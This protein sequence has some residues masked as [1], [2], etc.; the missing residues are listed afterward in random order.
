MR[1]RAIRSDR[2]SFRTVTFD[3]GL[4]IILA[5]KTARSSAKDTRNG[6]GK[7]LLIDI[8]HF[9]LGAEFNKSRLAVPQLHDWTFRLELEFDGHVVTA[10]RSTGHPKAVVVTGDN[11]GLGLPIKVMGRERT[12]ELDT[13][14]WCDHLGRLTFGLAPPD[15][16]SPPKLSFRSLV[17][18]FMRRDKQA[19]LSPFSFH[20]RMG[21]DEQRVC[22]A[23][24]L[25]LN[26]RYAQQWH[27]LKERRRVL[28]VLR[29]AA[30]SGLVEP[31]FGSRGKLEA[32]R[33][34]VASDV[35]KSAD[36]LA[37]FRVHPQYEYLE[38]KA[39]GLTREIHDLANANLRDRRLLEMYQ[40]STQDEDVDD[41]RVEEV[42]REAQMVFPKHVSRRLR[43][44]R[45]FHRDV[46][47]D[48]R[49]FLAVEAGRLERVVVDRERLMG[50]KT[51]DRAELLETLNTHGALSE[52]TKLRE[53]HDKLVV[54]LRDLERRLSNLKEFESGRSNLKIEQETLLQQTLHDLEQRTSTR[55]KA[56]A[57]FNSNSQ[58]L[59]DAPGNLIIEVDE[60]GY[61]FGVD[62]K[63]SGS[64]GIESMKVF[65]YDL[66]LAQLWSEREPKPGVLV[67]DS[68]IFDGVDERQ[69]A[70][71][72]RR[73]AA[74][75]DA[76][77]FQYI[78][79]LNSDDV[80]DS[81]YLGDLDIAKHLRI[82]LT[83]KVNGC[84]LG[85]RY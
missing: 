18:Y 77:G 84:L 58:A 47:S 46:V 26:W 76:R 33:V 79:S 41:S 54:D 9:C 8:V 27:M 39:N 10:S 23:F 2:S 28:N 22:N 45:Q 66:T 35:K 6:V 51:N 72:L 16:E 74:E 1:F 78:C 36:S 85:I 75:A 15:S 71:A 5:D 70:H 57:L 68:T 83:D 40:K 42:F 69:V 31:L 64:T 25:G 80:P 73:A 60:S 63:R 43:D 59:Y 24:L 11:E 55:E 65:C 20:A 34:R 17:S 38:K 56:M 30:K 62:I 32:E 61:R 49:K 3:A 67:H 37:S 13:Q 4:N 53:I 81:E 19:F 21:D 44:V 12:S 29:R 82:T 14:E 52:Y 7:S 48:R 50:A